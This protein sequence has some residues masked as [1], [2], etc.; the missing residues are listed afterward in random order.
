MS[1]ATTAPSIRADDDG[2]TAASRDG[3]DDLGI[4][5][6]PGEEQ[7]P[8][9]GQRDIDRVEPVGRVVTDGR[10]PGSF[11]QHSAA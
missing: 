4:G 8:M 3:R 9:S 6:R 5:C 7:R 2:L 10:Q 11:S 1:I